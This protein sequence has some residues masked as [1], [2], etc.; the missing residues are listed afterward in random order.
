MKERNP[1]Y[2]LLLVVS[3]LMVVTAL[4]Y[5][6]PPMRVQPDWLRLY[7]WRILIAEAVAV[8]VLGLLSMGLD[9]VRALRKKA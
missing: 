1:Y 6:L 4:A 9:R 7:G 2:L 3:V 8:V 5:A